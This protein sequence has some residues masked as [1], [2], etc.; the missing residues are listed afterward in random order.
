MKVSSNISH[1]FAEV[2][3]HYR[4]LLVAH[5]PMLV[6]IAL[7]A[8]SVGLPCIVLHDLTDFALSLS[9]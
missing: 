7:S 8:W 5:Y 6:S 1:L 3:Q 9:A 2:R 4:T